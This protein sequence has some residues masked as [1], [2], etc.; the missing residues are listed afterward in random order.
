MSHIEPGV[1]LALVLLALGFKR[2]LFGVL[3]LALLALW[4]FPPVAVLHSWALESH[5]PAQ[6]LPSG[7]AEVI[8]V[9]REA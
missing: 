8:V 9:F 7:D 3:G 5:Y 6:D 4:A 1:L 2:K